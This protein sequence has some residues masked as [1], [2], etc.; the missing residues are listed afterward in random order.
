[1]R[2]GFA[3]QAFH[4]SA[5][6]LVRMLVLLA[7]K[8][9]KAYTVARQKKSIART[10]CVSPR[11]FRADHDSPASSSYAHRHANGR[12]LKKYGKLPPRKYVHHD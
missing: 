3:L 1:M 8:V 5:P 12:E 4:N 11:Y 6:T 9:R 10:D 7:T 2:V